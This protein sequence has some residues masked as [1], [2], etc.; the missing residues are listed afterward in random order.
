MR[1]YDMT[2]LILMFAAALLCGATLLQ[3]QQKD[4]RNRGSWS[5]VIINGNCSVDE[6]FAESAK[7]TEKV[8][9]GKLSLYDD[10]IRQIYTLDPQDQ[11]NGHL[12]DAV[13]VEGALEGNTIHVQSVKM[14]TGIGLGAGQKAPAFSARDQFGGEQNLDTLKGPNGTILLFFRSADW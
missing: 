1:P 14:L 4:M 5:G 11:A 9:G 10:T 7:C 2:K 13:T 3:A 12:G 6:A 8:T